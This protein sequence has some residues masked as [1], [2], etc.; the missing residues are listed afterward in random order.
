MARSIVSVGTEASRAL[1]IIVRSVALASGSPPPSRADTSTWRISLAK[2]LPRA[3]SLAPFWCLIVAHFE[4]PD[5]SDPDL[6]QEL[7]V[8]PPIVR[9]LRVEGRRRDRALAHE[10]RAALVVGQHLDGRTGPLDPRSA[11]EHGVERLVEPDDVEIGLEGVDL[12]TVGVA[13]HRDVEDAEAA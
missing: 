13:A 11:D 4:C 12:A 7:L 9:Q 8:E 1:P 10:H 5:M 3:L 6:L 2:S